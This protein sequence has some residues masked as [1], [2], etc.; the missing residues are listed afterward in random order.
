[1]LSFSG[2]RQTE[3]DKYAKGGYCEYGTRAKESRYPLQILMKHDL[4]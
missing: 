4:L 3:I 1:M 2:H